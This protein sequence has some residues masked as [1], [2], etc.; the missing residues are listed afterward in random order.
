M[1]FTSDPLTE[2]PKWIRRSMDRVMS[3]CP[4][5]FESAREVLTSRQ[6]VMPSPGLTSQ[7][8]RPARLSR[9]GSVA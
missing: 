5:E 9:S 7:M 3:S 6:Q 2:S 4:L 1:S 8:D